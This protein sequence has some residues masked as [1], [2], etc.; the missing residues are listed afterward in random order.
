MT[1]VDDYLDS[2]DAHPVAKEFLEHARRPSSEQDFAWLTSHQPWVI[3]RGQRYLCSG[4]S[5]LGDVWIKRLG[6]S[7]YYDRRVAVDE[8]SG[9][10][11]RG[12]R[13]EADQGK[14]GE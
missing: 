13:G 9:W 5:R 3:W 11:A 2:G 7:A 12:G 8:L 4:A 1:H 14:S 6:S 10:E